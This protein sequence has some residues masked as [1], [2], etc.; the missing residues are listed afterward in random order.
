MLSRPRLRCCSEVNT[1]LS[2][3]AMDHQYNRDENGVITEISQDPL[4]CGVG[5][6]K[7]PVE[8][9]NSNIAIAYQ[10]MW[11]RWDMCT[12]FDCAAG[13]Q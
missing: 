11:V 9:K 8:A 12:A 6:V 7:N 1:I 2:Y 3:N 5:L 13:V 4:H 10:W